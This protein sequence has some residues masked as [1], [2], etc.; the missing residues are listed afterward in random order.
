MI[1][2][3]GI[4]FDGVMHTYE[5]GWADGSIYGDF[6]PGAPEAITHLMTQYAVFVFT[7]RNPHQVAIWL[8]GRGFRV[9]TEE[10]HEFW[11]EQG[12]LLITNRKLPAVAYLDDRGIRF[13]NWA[14]ALED[15]ERY[16]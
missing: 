10:P 9:T 3:L 6:V 5:L 4:D 12:R 7:S 11:N 15:I 14:Q 1:K 13:V 16:V 8:A 2:T